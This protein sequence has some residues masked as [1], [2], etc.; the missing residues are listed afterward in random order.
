MYEKWL[1][2]LWQMANLKTWFFII[3]FSKFFQIFFFVIL[4]VLID[5]FQML[6]AKNLEFFTYLSEKDPLDH[7]NSEKNHFFASFSSFSVILSSKIYLGRYFEKTLFMHRYVPPT[8]VYWTLKTAGRYDF[9]FKSYK[10]FF[11]LPSL[12]IPIVESSN[13]HFYPVC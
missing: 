8:V 13:F 11:H 3:I 9:P 12:K 5:L 6:Y 2:K 4:I 7:K 10:L 1:S